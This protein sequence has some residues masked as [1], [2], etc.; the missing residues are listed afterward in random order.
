M[1]YRAIRWFQGRSS[2]SGPS[3]PHTSFSKL[4]R[5]PTPV[6]NLIFLICKIKDLNFGQLSLR[7]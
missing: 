4:H 3:H 1:Q 5:K 7:N 6:P 2:Y